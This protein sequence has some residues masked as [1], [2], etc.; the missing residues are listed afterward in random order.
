MTTEI[1]N[2]SVE[3]CCSLFLLTLLGALVFRRKRTRSLLC[4][5][6]L[7]VGEI[8][9]VITDLIFRVAT[10]EKPMDG[11]LYLDFFIS[12]AASIFLVCTFYWYAL[13]RFEEKGS[14][15]FS[16][17]MR[18]WISVYSAVLIGLFVSSLWTGWFY[19][20]DDSGR[21]LYTEHFYWSFYP[22]IPLVLVDFFIIWRYRSVL[23]PL[24]TAAL[25]FY[26]IVPIAAAAADLRYGTV[27]AH[28]AV[29]LDACFLFEFIDAEQEQKLIRKE[30]EL[31][32]TQLTTLASQINPH[33]IYNTLGTIESL[34]R[35]QPEEAS[36]L[37]ASFSDYLSD[38]YMDMTKRPMI[39]FAEEL[40][41]VEH[42]LSIARVR[43]PN[44]KVIY[45]IQVSDF[46]VPCLSVQPLA[47]NA[48]R[49]GICRRRKSEGTL[50]I[51]SEE[52]E[53]AYVVRVEDDGVGFDPAAVPEDTR[54]HVGIENVTKRLA[55]LCGGTL[56][57]Q[58]KIGEGTECKIIL[59]KEGS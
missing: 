32:E 53:K 13:A 29:T 30:K 47:E 43:F 11:G 34:G 25:F 42:Y 31:A 12:Y 44:L 52:T 28:L 14:A 57:I 5:A 24:E 35:T 41:H 51:S 33:F 4:I 17:S 40:D 54:P 37:I 26:C 39:P 3:I 22:I 46:D 16:M 19:T 49:H 27:L 15:R 6:L 8:I 58:S 45:N 23:G 2:I 36:K 18:R 38:N 59:P 56:T 9:A 50:R 10:I 48:V 1:A 7:I 21:L 20:V 55:L